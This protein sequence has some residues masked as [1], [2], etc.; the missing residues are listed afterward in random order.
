LT[1]GSQ[2]TPP[3]IWARA[4]AIIKIP[5]TVMRNV[6]TAH[7]MLKVRSLGE[8]KETGARSGVPKSRTAP[9]SFG[10]SETPWSPLV[11]T[12]DPGLLVGA[13][14]APT[15]VG[16]GSGDAKGDEGEASGVRLGPGETSGSGIGD[17]TG[18]SVVV[19]R[20]VSVGLGDRVGPADGA[21]LGD[22]DAGAGVGVLRGVGVG[23]GN[24]VG[25]GVG[26]GV[27]VGV[28]VGVGTGVGVD[29]GAARTV[30][31]TVVAS[32]AWAVPSNGRYVKTS[33]PLNPPS[34]W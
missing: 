19:G 27:G 29:T 15:S 9:P 31:E 32:R 30:I 5:G 1:S 24:G 20:G 22:A 33:T 7:S 12:R 2:A 10:R 34:G 23:V 21:G 11:C 4:I 17:S 28:G 3:T 25:V 6:G 16:V 13:R 18:A 14:S 8:P 26:L